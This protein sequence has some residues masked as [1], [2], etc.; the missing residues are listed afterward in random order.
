MHVEAHDPVEELR[1]RMRREQV[2]K[3][4]QRL[5]IVVLAME[6]RTAREIAQWVDL[7]ERQVQHWI[8]RYNQEGASG[9]EDHAGRG[10]VPMLTLEEAQRLR[11]RLDAKPLPDDRVCSLRGKDVQRIL[12][13]EFGKRR[14]LGAVY[15]LLHQLGYSSLAPRPQHRKANPKAQEA[16]KKTFPGTLPRCVKHIPTA[17][18]KFSFKTKPALASKAL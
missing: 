16:F 4:A 7:S 14:K 9:L 6:G 13:Q 3:R 11:T 10:P 1:Q 5:R 2:A 17:R 15:K 18:C 12:E 8:R